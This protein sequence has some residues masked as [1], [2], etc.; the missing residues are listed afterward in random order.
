[1][2]LQKLV[3]ESVGTLVSYRTRTIKVQGQIPST[4]RDTSYGNLPTTVLLY[5]SDSSINLM[6]LGEKRW[7]SKQGPTKVV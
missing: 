3:V 1:M 5:V 4:R 7:S 2:Y 6:T